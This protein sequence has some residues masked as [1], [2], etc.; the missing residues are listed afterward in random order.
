MK[1]G[2]IDMASPMDETSAQQAAAVLQKVAGLTKIAISTASG[3]IAVD[4]DGEQTSVQEM[5]ALL[6]RAGF[7]LKPGGHGEGGCCGSCGGR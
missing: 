6:Q 7:T 3:R 2:T 4:Y 5:R 1:T